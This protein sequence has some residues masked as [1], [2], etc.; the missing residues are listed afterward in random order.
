MDCRMIRRA[1]MAA[2]TAS[3]FSLGSAH[4]ATDTLRIQDYP[5]IGNFLARV[6][7]ANGYCEQHGIKCEL[8][9]IPS[10]PLGLQT[11][12]AGDIDVA[13][14]PPEVLIQAMNKGANLRV[15]GSGARA[16]IFFLMASTGMKTPDAA[17]GYPAVMHDF[18]GK[19]IGVTARGSA[20]EFQLKTLLEGA[21]MKADDVT[22]IP[23][24]SPNTAF[25]AIAHNQIDGLM[26]FSPMDGF[27]AVTKACRVVVD[28]RK[29]QGPAALLGMNGAAVVQIVTV[30]FAAINRKVFDEYKAAMQEAD[31]FIQKPENYPAV[32]KIA[33]DTFK[34]QAP[35]GD[36]ILDVALRNA[37]PGLR[38]AVDPRALQNAAQ[39]MKETGQINKV[40]DTSKLLLAN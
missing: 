33:E 13:F 40:I 16:P 11:L 12:L 3:L 2:I 26:L 23:V 8:R 34:I 30:K 36:Q 4:A 39:Y 18:K 1:L 15:I 7:N 14:G 31:D 37:I 17:K 21:G 22:I 24:G 19:K 9:Q 6:A 29:G 35:H 38:Y 27:C 25:P 10:A 20:A 5:G 32:L 28:P